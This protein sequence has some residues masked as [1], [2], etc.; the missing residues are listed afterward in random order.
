MKAYL[1]PRS[2][3]S[4]DEDESDYIVALILIAQLPKSSS[5][6]YL[7]LEEMHKCAAN[8][9]LAHQPLNEVKRY[10][11]DEESP[12]NFRLTRQA[13]S[14]L[15]NVLERNIVQNEEMGQISSASS[16]DV[17][18]QIAM[19]L[20]IL[21]RAQYH[22]VMTTFGIPRPTAY[23]IMHSVCTAVIS[24]LSLPR[25]PL[26]LQSPVKKQLQL[27]RTVDHFKPH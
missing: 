17:Q 2:M 24:E 21:A 8:R 16:I 5:E 11:A 19:F 1:H 4:L 3:P 26:T 25:I 13:F 23:K 9:I 15:C 14:L 12:H 27:F 18:L 6:C 20:R 22:D 7:M 10:M